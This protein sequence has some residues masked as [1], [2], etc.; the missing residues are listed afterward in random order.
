MKRNLYLASVLWLLALGF[1]TSC[2]S[3]DSKGVRYLPV[4]VLNSTLWSIVDTESGEVLY[5]DEFRQMPSAI[6]DGI[7]YMENDEGLYYLYS[8]DNVKRPINAKPFKAITGFTSEGKALAVEPGGTIKVID[9]KAAVLRDLG[10]DVKGAALLVG[11]LISFRSAEGKQGVMNLDGNVVLDALYDEV[12]AISE[13]GMILGVVKVDEDSVNYSVMDNQGHLKFEFNQNDY[14]SFGSF[15][16]GFLPVSVED[17]EVFFLNTE[18][19]KTGPV[20]EYDTQYDCYFY[21]YV[22]GLTPFKEGHLWGLKNKKG[23]IMLRAKYDQLSLYDDVVVAGMEGEYGVMTREDELLLPF[24]YEDFLYLGKGRY[25]VKM[26][27]VYSLIDG[28]GKDVCKLLFDGVNTF[29][30]IEVESDFSDN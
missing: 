7:F 3:S 27:N 28:K 22:D 1:F 12:K 8:V 19:E 17:D 6:D 29:S 25:V 9:R 24:K 16:E 26:D 10:P 2:G 21:G 11:G 15:R 4:Q 5:Q 20:G 18:G 30:G 14:I 23:E 13:D